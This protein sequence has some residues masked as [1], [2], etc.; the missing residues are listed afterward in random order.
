MTKP[1][2]I[3]SLIGRVMEADPKATRIIYERRTKVLT[4]ELVDANAWVELTEDIELPL[5]GRD[6]YYAGVTELRREQRFMLMWDCSE[7]GHEKPEIG[8]G[9]EFGGKSAHKAARRRVSEQEDDGAEMIGG[10]RHVGSGAIPGLKSDASSA[11]W[12]QEAK[13]TKHKSFKLTQEV[14]EKISREARTQDK[15][16]MVFL[17]FTDVPEDVMVE[18]DWVIIPRSAFEEM[19]G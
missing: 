16:P 4:V 10:R 3:S 11:T 14:L 8:T 5:K 17:R 18:S 7:I 12:Q 6:S 13:Q 19:D 9:F 2:K 1:R 15:R